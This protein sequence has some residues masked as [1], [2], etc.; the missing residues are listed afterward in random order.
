MAQMPV[1]IIDD[2]EMNQQLLSY[3]LGAAGFEVHVADD[4][5][6]AMAQLQTLRPRLILMDL[7]LPGMGGL[8]LTRHI[9]ADP[10]HRDATIVA[11]TAY[12]M[13]GD[14]QKALEA[15]CDGYVA[16]PIQTSSFVRTVTG[17]MAA[18]GAAPRS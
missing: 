5:A 11:V 3:L 9:K 10:V 12:A 1:L 15:G 2:N 18:R 13:K 8:E 6:Q 16:K 4:A 14:E 17:F 7:Q